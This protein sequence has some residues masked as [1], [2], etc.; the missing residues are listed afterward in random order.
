VAT[1]PLPA[2]QVQT[3][4]ITGQISKALQIRSL[5][6]GQQIQQGQLQSQQQQQE[7]R[8]MDLDA[9]KRI[10]QAQRD[11]GWDA[12]DGDKTVQML[13]HYGVPIEYQQRVLQ[14]I[15][16][17]RKLIQSQS[18]ENLGNIQTF[19]EFLDDQYQ[20]VAAAPVGERQSAWQ[21]AIDN[22]RRYVGQLPPGPSRDSLS[23]NID[24]IPALYD[25][26]FIAR[27]HGLLRSA[28]QIHEDELKKA[29][30]KEALGKGS[31]QEQQATN[32]RAKSDPTSPLF[33]PTAAATAIGAQGG[34]P[35]ATA[36]QAG[37]AA[38]AGAVEGAKAAA[39]FPF[40]KQLETIR[41]QVSMQFQTNKDAT[42]KIEAS[43]LKPFEDKM[44]SIAQLQSAVQQ[45]SQGNVTA[46]RAVALKLIGVTNP[47]GTKRYNEAEA[48]RMISQG[49]V[50][51]R[52][53]G[54][55]KN[56]L[57][58]DNWTD[59]MQSDMLGFGNAQ[60]DVA[61]N[62]LNR[63][64]ANV[65]RLYGT[66]VGSGLLQSN[67]VTMK[68]PNGQTKE[69]PADQVEHYKSMGATVVNQ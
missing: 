49:N 42:D 56:L 43:V 55:I 52:V 12:T 47:E 4:D 13:T 33:D 30:T 2:T 23:K 34:T 51:E 3:P 60:A 1:I 63:G 46:A 6:L 65:N 40:Q 59:R 10:I 54:T 16:E 53:K 15:G 36:A 62:N 20:G 37:E 22:A 29:Q 5:M 26:N 18:A 9:Q 8:A 44:T 50:P 25:P 38:Q 61:R 24:A 45:A 48:E 7:V 39:Q 21:E 67:T 41:Q 68:A 32:L 11:P 31:E 17:T 57:T 14:G 66:S 28:M 19:H 69:V 35:W 27:E 58:G 64:I